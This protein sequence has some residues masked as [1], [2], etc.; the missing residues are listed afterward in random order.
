MSY[1][2]GQHGIA[3][4]HFTL[5]LRLAKAAD[6]RLYGAHLLANLATQAVY[7]GHAPNAT[8]LAEAAIDGAGRAPAAVRARLYT[9]VASAYG[10]S[11]ERRACQTALGR[12]ER[13]IDRASPGEGPRW[14]GYF[15]PAHVAGSAIRSLSDLRLYRQALRHASDAITVGQ[16]NARTRVLHTALIAMTHAQAGDVD[17]ACA[18]GVELAEQ[19]PAVDSARVA[20]R[21]RELA[22]ALNPYLANPQVADLLHGLRSNLRRE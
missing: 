19:T 13:A 20:H 11:G 6:D 22:A 16:H 2:A 7:L 21:V 12:A 3:Q 5:A 17:A 9:T 10:R 8:R 15:S 4:Q 18:W 14:V 1:D